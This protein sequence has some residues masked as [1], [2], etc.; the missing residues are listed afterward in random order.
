MRECQCCAAGL[1]CFPLL[2]FSKLLAQCCSNRHWRVHSDA[3]LQPG[4]VQ[5]RSACRHHADQLHHAM[6]KPSHLKLACNSLLG[7]HHNSLCCCPAGNLMVFTA[8]NYKTM[9]FVRLGV[10]LQVGCSTAAV[11]CDCRKAWK[12]TLGC[13]RVCYGPR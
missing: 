6:C 7:H 12:A 4:N 8:G 5:P 3:R 1:I 9:D 10:L 11:S 2:C 13:T